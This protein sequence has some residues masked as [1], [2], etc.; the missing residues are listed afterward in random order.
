MKAR[1]FPIF[2]A[3]AWFAILG[4]GLGCARKA[5]DAKITSTIQSSFNADSGLQ[6][7]QLGVQ[8]ENGVVTLSGTVDN[9]AQRT[10]ASR[11]AAAAPGVKQVI[12][13]LQV[14]AGP[15]E[16]AQAQPAPSVQPAPAP[17]P[18]EKPSPSRRRKR[19][20]SSGDSSNQNPNGS[21]D[22]MAQAG[23]SIPAA[24]P[25]P[26]MQAP[27]PPPPPPPPQKVTIPSGTTVSVR[28]VDSVGSDTSQQ[29]QTF[30]ATLNSPLSVQGEVAIPAGYDVEGHVVDVENGGK[31]T[32]KA[33]LTLQ[34]DRVIVNGKRYDIQ[35]DTYH[36]E[37]KSRTTNSAEKVGAGSVL[38]AIIGGLAGGGKGA[39]IGAGAGAGV[40]GGAQAASKAPQVRLPSETVLTFTMQAP[41][42]VVQTSGGP[43]RDRPRLESAQPRLDSGQPSAGS[44]QP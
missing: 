7:K 17:V 1:I 44:S 12:N 24:A 20:V 19:V 9:D 37:T 30:H 11:Y 26:A 28:L 40:G 15:A 43:D 4:M 41:L 39:A 32:G 8:S 13:D 14:G 25:E 27:P 36:R 35:T 18:A 5:D 16:T 42:T 31:F 29:G 10:A 23:N 33:Q 3:M 21:S 6:G 38:G 2:A 34:L 22:Q